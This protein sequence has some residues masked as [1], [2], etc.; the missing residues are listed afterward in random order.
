MVNKPIQSSVLPKD[1]IKWEPVEFIK[2]FQAQECLNCG[3]KEKIMF[4]DHLGNWKC[5]K[6]EQLRKGL[7]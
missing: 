4:T 5:S 2:L 7:K 1:E 3:R 6:H